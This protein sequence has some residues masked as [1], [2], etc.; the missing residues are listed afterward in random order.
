V[1]IRRLL[2]RV[3]RTEPETPRKLLR[4]K[5]RAIGFYISADTATITR[6]C[7]R[8][9]RAKPRDQLVGRRIGCKKPKKGKPS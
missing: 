2:G 3:R 6:V 9:G 7:R 4:D 5:L 1:E 8:S